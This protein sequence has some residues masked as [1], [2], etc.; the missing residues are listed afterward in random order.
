VLDSVGTSFVLV[1]DDAVK[2]IEVFFDLQETAEKK[3][4]APLEKGSIRFEDTVYLAIL[5]FSK[6]E[7][8]NF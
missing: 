2:V 6:R 1:L 7:F 8:R 5:T 3:L 4:N